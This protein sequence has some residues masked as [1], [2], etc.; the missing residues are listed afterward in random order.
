ME[1]FTAKLSSQRTRAL[2]YN[3]EN[4][5]TIAATYE[6]AR[7]T[8]VAAPVEVRPEEAPKD[9][10]EEINRKN[11][12]LDAIRHEAAMV[13]DSRQTLVRDPMVQAS[14]TETVSLDKLP[15]II[16]QA[17]DAAMIRKLKKR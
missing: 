4:D 10:F 16:R 12:E 2:F 9:P 1:P 8:N 6:N 15:A 14:K 7:S 3:A 5:K 13:S 11:A 17:A